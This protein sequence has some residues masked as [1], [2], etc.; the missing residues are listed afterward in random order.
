[1][2]DH[3]DGNRANTRDL[4]YDQRRIVPSGKDSRE[5]EGDIASLETRQFQNIAEARKVAAA[6]NNSSNNA[7]EI[8]DKKQL[9]EQQRPDRE[10][11]NSW[12]DNVSD[13]DRSTPESP[14]SISLRKLVGLQVVAAYGD[15]L[16][17]DDSGIDSWAQSQG[18]VGTLEPREMCC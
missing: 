17:D 16:S 13:N 18:T 11:N 15:D 10:T 7:T 14:Q 4:P 5:L 12:E 9:E 1:M 6:D 3:V 2:L 8:P